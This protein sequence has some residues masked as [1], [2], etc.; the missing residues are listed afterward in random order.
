MSSL[1][2][3]R[4]K[5]PPQVIRDA[6][7]ICIYSSMKS[8]LPPFG[9]MNGTGL[10]LGR[11]PDGSWSAPSAILPNYYSTGFMIGVDVVDVRSK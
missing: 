8:G 3:G 2:I 4:K 1:L 6:K 7:G 9:G 11:L 5:I 10:L